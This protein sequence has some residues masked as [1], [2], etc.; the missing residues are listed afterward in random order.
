MAAP[1]PS[2][3]REARAEVAAEVARRRRAE[4]LAGSGAGR[5]QVSGARGRPAHRGRSGYVGLGAACRVCLRL[6]LA[7]APP[8]QCPDCP[9]RW[10]L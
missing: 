9:G 3:R 1:R 10:L 2:L 4:V 8:E 7:A 5:V 6:R